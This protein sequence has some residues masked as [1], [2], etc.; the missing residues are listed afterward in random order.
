MGDALHVVLQKWFGL[1]EGVSWG[2]WKCLD[3][4]KIRRHKYGPQKCKKCGQ[5]MV[6]EEYDLPKKKGIPFSGHIDGLM[7]FPV[8]GKY[9]VDFKGSSAEKI[10]YI[11]RDNRP[12][13]YHYFQTNAYAN[14]VNMY[15]KHFG[16]F[17][18]VEGIIIIYVDRGMANRLWHPLFV[19]VSKRVFRQ[20]IGLID[21]GAESLENLH[22]PNGICSSPRDPQGKWCKVRD[23]CFSR[24][25]DATLKDKV[26]PIQKQ[27][28][29]PS[30]IKRSLVDH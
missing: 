1:Q 26:W 30:M 4:R 5:E 21:E 22:L 25:V 16:G 23:L 11:Q 18:P 20:C 7:D 29:K 10:R 27:D 8:S 17:G 15:P 2:N 24:M 13:D 14:V 6:Y 19:P 3:C 9:L 12:Y 28:G